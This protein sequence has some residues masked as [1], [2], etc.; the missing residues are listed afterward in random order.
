MGQQRAYSTKQFAINVK[1]V[2]GR[3]LVRPTFTFAASEDS[4]PVT[5]TCE[6]AELKSDLAAATLGIVCHNGTIDVGDVRAV[7]P[8]TIER[9][10]PLDEASKRG[11]K[12]ASDLAL[13]QVPYE[14]KMQQ[15]AIDEWRDRLRA[16]RP[17]K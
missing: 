2:D 8:D 1:R 3:K 4:P 10:I 7:F 17:S 16:P 9:V 14:M 11:V 5:I 13:Y 15:Q 6:E 12:G